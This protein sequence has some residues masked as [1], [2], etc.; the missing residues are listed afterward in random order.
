MG[1]QLLF[2]RRNS[3]DSTGQCTGWDRAACCFVTEPEGFLVLVGADHEVADVHCHR[4][5]FHFQIFSLGPAP[6]GMAS[7]LPYTRGH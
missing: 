4:C 2:C 3:M 6:Q 7:H 5:I 1:R